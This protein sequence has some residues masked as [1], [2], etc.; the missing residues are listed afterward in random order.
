MSL[1]NL[2]SGRIAKSSGRQ[3]VIPRLNEFLLSL[4]N[5]DR[6]RRYPQWSRDLRAK[7]SR[8]DYRFH[9]SGVDADFCPREW[10]IDQHGLGTGEEGRTVDS[11]GMRIFE[12]GD[13]IHTMVQWWMAEMGVLYGRWIC[14]RM[15]ETHVFWGTS[16]LYCPS[17]KSQQLLVYREVPIDHEASGIL[18]HDDGELLLPGVGR[19]MVDVKSSNSRIYDSLSED[20]IDKH[21]HQITQYLWARNQPDGWMTHLGE[22]PLPKPYDTVVAAVILYYNKDGS[23][24]R[25]HVLRPSP[26]LY[27]EIMAPKLDAFAEAKRFKPG[28]LSTLPARPCAN[29]AEGNQRRCA[30]VTPC[31]TLP[32]VL[33]P[34][35]RKANG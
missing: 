21:R 23:Q 7:P 19:V 8:H 24:L 2:L 32:P 33:T 16:L 15:P 18:G 3:L 22:T 17:C 28:K 13:S 6:E 11:N 10:I 29:Q 1:K 4:R 35:K 34:L 9:P 27:D 30:Y 20:P 31:F 12:L 14:P 26:E 25:E 5:D